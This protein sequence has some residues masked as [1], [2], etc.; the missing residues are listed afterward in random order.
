VRIELGRHVLE[1]ATVLGT[2]LSAVGARLGRA[3]PVI[4]GRGLFRAFVVDLDYPCSRL[5]LHDAATYSYA[6]PGRTIELLPGEGGRRL[7][8]VRVEDLAPAW[9]A[10]D[11]G[12]GNAIDLFD[13]YWRDQRLLAGRRTSTQHGGGVGGTIV[14]R[15]AT[16]RSV[17]LAGY[18]LRDVPASFI[19]GGGGGS[20][21]TDAIDGNVGADVLSRFRVIVDYGRDRAHVEP[22]PD[23]QSRPFRK[24]RVGLGGSFDEDGVLVT[25]VAPGS[26]ADKAGW[27]AGQ[28]ITSIDGRPITAGSWREAV[29]AWRKMPAGTAIRL[30]DGEGRV[31]ELAASDYY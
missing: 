26:P 9:F 15:L 17:K 13:G 18:E 31:H 16:L 20:F 10:F 30:T 28:R 25:V 3:I 23:W 6:G 4:L 8:P 2:D 19:E 21:D 14:A 11:T 12:S 1:P 5:A 24:D 27:K 22:G 7:M 29:F